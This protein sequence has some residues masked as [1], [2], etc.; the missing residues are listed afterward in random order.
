MTKVTNKTNEICSELSMDE[1]VQT[2]EQEQDRTVASIAS[3]EL[4]LQKKKKFSKHK[5]YFT[6]MRIA[7]IAIFTAMSFALRFWEF[8]ILPAVDFLKFDFSD[9]FVLISGY[10]L[11]PIS[12]VIV[13]VMKEVIYGIF[14]TKTSFVGE[15]ANI[16]ILVP[17]V[18]LPSLMY[19]KRKGIKSVMFWIVIACLMRTVWSFPVNYLLNFPVFVG[20]N[21]EKGMSMFL[22]VWY[23]VMLFNLIKCL[24][25]A[26]V[27]LL[28]YKSISRVIQIINNKIA[29]SSGEDSA[30]SQPIDAQSD[31]SSE[32]NQA[33]TILDGTSEQ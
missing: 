9:I 11:G 3:G 1:S 25:L 27:V 15:V 23:W 14:F 30:P 2:A 32:A 19:K 10:A 7:Y 20:F 26:V 28:L 21:W 13:G 31:G 29:E 17:F 6:A 22:G 8:P 12:G 33:E 18:L 5:V 4:P 24:I 16:V